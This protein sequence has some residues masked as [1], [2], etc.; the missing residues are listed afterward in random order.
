M[1]RHWSAAAIKPE[2][3]AQTQYETKGI[4]GDLSHDPE[5]EEI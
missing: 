3:L 5:A 2:S 1:C 4:E